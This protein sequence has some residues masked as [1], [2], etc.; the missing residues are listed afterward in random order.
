MYK[1]TYYY[2]NI[3]YKLYKYEFN[4]LY[5]HFEKIKEITVCIVNFCVYR[6]RQKKKQFNSD[7]Q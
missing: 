7:D 4:C 3:V 6:Q 5:I 2:D 1:F